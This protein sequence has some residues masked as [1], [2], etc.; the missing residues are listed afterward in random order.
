MP[1]PICRRPPGLNDVP[2]TH[3]SLCYLGG[4]FVDATQKPV[5]SWTGTLTRD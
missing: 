5:S 3:Y 4:P 1:L 2:C